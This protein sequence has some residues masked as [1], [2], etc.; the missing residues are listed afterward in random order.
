MKTLRADVAIAN[1]CMDCIY[2][3]YVAAVE[4]FGGDPNTPE[5]KKEGEQYARKKFLEIAGDFEKVYGP[6]TWYES[7]E[8]E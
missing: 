8:E 2:T 1:I 4:S 7:D 3:M 6:W 5:A